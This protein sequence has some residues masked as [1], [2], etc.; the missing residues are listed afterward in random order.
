MTLQLRKFDAIIIVVMIVAAGLFFYKSGYIDSIL[1]PVGPTPPDENT[2][3]P[4]VEQPLP[5]TS[6]MPAYRRDVSPEDE[7]VH[8][9]TLRVTREWWYYTAVFNDP[10]SELRDWSVAVSFNH[11]A[12]SDFLGSMKPDLLVVSLFSNQSDSYGGMINKKRYLDILNEGTL[13]AHSPGVSVQFEDSWA[14]GQSPTW[15]VHAED[16]DIDEAH[17]IIVDLEYTANSI[18][19]WTLGTRAFDKSEGELASY[20]FIGCT[21]TGTITLDGTTYHVKGMG[22]HEHTWTPN[23]LTRATINGWDWFSIS[24]D[25][26]YQLYATNYLPFPAIISGKL[27]RLDPF[28]T[29]LFSPDNGKTVTELKDVDLKITSQDQR[30]FPF[31]KMP[32][33]FDL[34]SSP[35]LNPLYTLSQSLLLGTHLTLNADINVGPSINKVWKFP[36]YIGMKISA[37]QIDGTI[38]WTDNDGDH[39]LEVHG[40]GVSWSMRALL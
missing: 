12:R 19:I 9:D 34:T 33:S 6:L 13:I 25:N 20:V 10:S 29:L 11:M 32:T 2:T 40:L 14:E 18:P 4:P 22:Q 16:N 24:F 1:P 17:D 35:S 23:I 8:F 15:H 37:C 5:P 28:G 31:V 21:I 30:I 26:G 27:S 3:E 7:G 36:S 38:S 39:E